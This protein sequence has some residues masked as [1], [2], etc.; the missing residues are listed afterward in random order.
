M[1]ITGQ[2]NLPASVPVKC[3]T[4]GPGLPL[5]AAPSTSAATSWRS[6]TYSRTTLAGSPLRIDDRRLQAGLVHDLADGAADDSLDAQPLLFLHRRLDAAPLDEILRLD[7]RQHF[8]L[9]V[10]LDR[11]AGGEAQRNARLGAVV[12]HD[13]IGA[14]RLALPHAEQV[15][16]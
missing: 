13:Q 2:G 11:A 12:D 10:G 7:D 3:A 8:D 1:I 15:L 14:F 9:P 16:R 4:S 5:G 6:P